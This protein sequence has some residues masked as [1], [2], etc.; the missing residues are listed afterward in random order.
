MR[1]LWVRLALFFGEEPVK[2]DLLAELPTEASFVRSANNPVEKFDVECDR[3]MMYVYGQTAMLHD[4]CCKR[5]LVKEKSYAHRYTPGK[6][7]Q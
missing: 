7:S 2:G 3:K 4:L 5:G 6:R 1:R